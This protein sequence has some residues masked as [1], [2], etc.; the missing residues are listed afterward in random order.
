MGDQRPATGVRSF[1]IDGGRIEV[2]ELPGGPG[3]PLL[4]LG[5]VELG[6]RPLAGTDTVLM[7]R[8]LRRAERRRVVVVG[9][10][11]PDDPAD[12]SLLLHPRAAAKA[13]ARA[14]ALAGLADRSLGVEAE[15]G[16]GRI[17][18]W[19]ALD[20]PELVARLVLASVAA[21]TPTGSPMAERLGRW[22][23]LAEARD[24][25][26]LFAGFAQQMRPAG[27]SGAPDAFT[28]AA[29]LQP[30]PS[31]PERFIAELRATLDPSSF[32]THRLREIR[33]PTLVLAGGRDQ[34]VPAD[35]SQ[36]VAE[37]IPGARFELDPE[38]GHTVRTAFRG[39]DELVEAFLAE[40]DP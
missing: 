20:H 1:P 6:L 11:I 35:V 18:L 12:A 17:S 8:W 21:E 14:V 28:A 19:L 31:T 22:I 13:V 40:G 10:P 16:G 32:V 36:G 23:A 4:V 2:F 39:Y 15:S 30:H 37:G 38:C 7:N 29:R 33:V 9:R 25:G 24:W 5:G 34:V 26:R 3:R 27:E